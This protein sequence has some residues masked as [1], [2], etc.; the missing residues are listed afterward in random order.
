MPPAGTPIRTEDIGRALRTAL[1]GATAADF[2]SALATRLGVDGVWGTSSGRASLSVVL[3]CLRRLRPER[4]VVALPAYTCFSVAASIVRSGLT[5]FPI[6][7]NPDT[8]DLDPNQLNNLPEKNLLCI[9]TSN[10]FGYVG[11]IT[12]VRYAAQPRGAFVV[13]N[14]AQ[15]LGARRDGQLAGT[16]G[17]VGIFSLGRGK[18]L[19]AIEGGLIIANGEELSRAVE[20]EVKPLR[21]AS[22]THTAFLLLQLAAYTALLHPTRYWIPNS[23]PFLKLGMTE[24]EPQFPMHTL[25]PLARHLLLAQWDRIPAL[26]AMRR[27]NAARLTEGLRASRTFYFPRPAPGTQAALLRLPV[28]APEEDMR[29]VAVKHLR[30]A[31]IGASC[32]YPSAICDIPGIGPHMA[33]TSHH[34]SNAERVSRT[35]FT[36]PVHP[37]VHAADITRMIEVLRNLEKEDAYRTPYREYLSAKEAQ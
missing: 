18:S 3:K 36:L 13:D 26:N 8:L 11:D 31:R 21:P 30:Q 35:L 9:I 32:F 17:D 6:D 34:C 37:F 19:S 10:L 20:A 7:V 2:A 16:R 5:L 24:F 23:L 25:Q 22:P 4:T 14:G 29:N 1:T 12:P 33:R 15:A 28:I 27:S